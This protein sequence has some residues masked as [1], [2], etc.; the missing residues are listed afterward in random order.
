MVDRELFSKRA[1]VSELANEWIYRRYLM[2]KDRFKHL[3]EELSIPEYVVLYLVA[4]M[5][6]D[7][8]E[9]EGSKK[10]YV[11]D[12]AS[13]MELTMP[14]LSAVIGKLN[15]KGMLKW[16]HDG[17]GSGGTYVVLT[18]FGHDALVHQEEA[19]KAHFGQVIEHFGKENFIQLLKLMKQLDDV[20]N[21]VMND[22][23]NDLSEE[24]S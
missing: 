23:L 13:R 5:E 9:D 21:D 11:K 7:T 22:E 3:F 19:L 10:I 8:E 2:G 18:K 24:D 20:M 17:L 14:Q 15:D 1:N 6:E 16:S 12:I 4:V